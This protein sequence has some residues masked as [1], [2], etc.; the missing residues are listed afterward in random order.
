MIMMLSVLG[1]IQYD[2][3]IST[4]L[5]LVVI[6]A[7]HFWRFDDLYN[8]PYRVPNIHGIVVVFL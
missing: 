2:M 7:R 6:L 8:V 5:V 3:L 1:R 4:I